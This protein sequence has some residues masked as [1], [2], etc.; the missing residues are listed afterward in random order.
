LA[1]FYLCFLCLLFQNQ[2]RQFGDR[3][4]VSGEDGKEITPIWGYF[5]GDFHFLR[6]ILLFFFF[7]VFFSLSTGT[8]HLWIFF[9]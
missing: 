9:L 8:Q 2:S 6:R 3:L 7:F 4:K 1:P 5:E